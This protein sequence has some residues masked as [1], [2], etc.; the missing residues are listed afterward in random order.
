MFPSAST[1]LVP[2][3]FAPADAINA[4]L[5]W[6]DQD[7]DNK[8]VEV[9]WQ[10]GWRVTRIRDDREDDYK[11]GYYGNHYFV[12]E[13]IW[14]N[15][16]NP[17]LQHQL[18]SNSLYDGYYFQSTNDDWKKVRAFNNRVKEEMLK[19]HKFGVPSLIWEPVRGR[20][21]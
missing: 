17:L 13:I 20:T 8:I 7:I 16:A 9:N 3:Q 19:L 2:V 18:T 4:C 15:F 14:R 1:N 5:L 6:S 21:C 12:A 10:N 11:K